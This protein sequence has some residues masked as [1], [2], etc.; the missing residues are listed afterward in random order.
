MRTSQCSKCHRNVCCCR[1]S[2]AN[3]PA[4]PPGLPGSRGLP[5]VN[6]LPGPAGPPGSTGLTGP[7][8]PPGSSITPASVGTFLFFSGNAPAN[9]VSR[10]TNSLDSTGLADTSVN[11]PRYDFP[12]DAEATDFS[13]IVLDGFGGEVIVDL[14]NGNS[15]V[16]TSITFSGFV[17]P[18]AKQRVAITPPQL[19][20][21]GVELNVRVTNNDDANCRLTATARLNVFD[22]P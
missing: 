10:L 7:Q 2:L 17:A 8:G 18:G 16:I 4:G 3:G 21:I 15:L 12:T 1:P 19:L 9:A 6:G 11:Y 13:V 22:T 14:M 5:G 20:P